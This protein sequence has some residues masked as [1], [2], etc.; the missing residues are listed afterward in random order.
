MRPRDAHD[1]RFVD[2]VARVHDLVREVAVVREDDQALA[3][4]VEPA[5]GV[6]AALSPDP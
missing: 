6:D 3:L 5:D 2:A 4:L 1:V